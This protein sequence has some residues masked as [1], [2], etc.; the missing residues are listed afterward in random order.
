[1]ATSSVALDAL[2]GIGALALVELLALAVDVRGAH[3]PGVRVLD[4]LATLAIALAVVGGLTAVVAWSITL[5][6][7]D[8]A[9]LAALG[10]AAV[11]LVTRL[12]VSLGSAASR[13]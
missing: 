13:S 10:V 3:R 9:V 1:M 6:V 11:V 8:A 4:R 2:I 7:E 5:P 12:V